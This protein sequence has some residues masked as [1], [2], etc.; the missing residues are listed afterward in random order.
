MGW[1][2]MVRSRS[3][4]SSHLLHHELIARREK[5]FVPSALGWKEPRCHTALRDHETTI[6]PVHRHRLFGR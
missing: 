1:G 4:L 5:Y 6:L 3:P 2:K